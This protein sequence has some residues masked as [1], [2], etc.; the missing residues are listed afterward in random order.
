M[1]TSRF[2]F[3]GRHIKIR[4]KKV[5]QVIYHWTHSQLWLYDCN[6]N[7]HWNTTPPP[8]THTHTH[9]KTKTKKEEEEEETHLKKTGYTRAKRNKIWNNHLKNKNKLNVW[10]ANTITN[11]HYYHSFYLHASSSS[12]ATAWLELQRLHSQH[13]AMVATSRA[14]SASPRPTHIMACVDSHHAETPHSLCFKTHH[15]LCHAETPHSLCFKT[16]HGL[17]WQPPCWNTT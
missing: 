9:P 12:T 4:K 8:S 1:L 16:H 17:C 6:T 11:F 13:S 5:S 7:T 3:E 15:G 14:N 10:T 2:S